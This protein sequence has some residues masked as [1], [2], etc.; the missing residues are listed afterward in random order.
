MQWRIATDSGGSQSGIINL[1]LPGQVASI[2]AGSRVF[3]PVSLIEDSWLI[4]GLYPVEEGP[5]NGFRRIRYVNDVGDT[6]EFS[7]SDGWGIVGL[8]IDF[9][10]V[11][12]DGQPDNVCIPKP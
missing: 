11:R 8:F 4:A 7:T 6:V 2:P 10:V 1:F 5:N 12:T 3:G 9:T